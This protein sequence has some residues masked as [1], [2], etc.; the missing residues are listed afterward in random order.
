MHN[1]YKMYVEMCYEE[2]ASI[3]T[4]CLHTNY[5]IR[6]SNGALATYIHY[7]QW[8]VGISHCSV[9]FYLRKQCASTI[10]VYFSVVCG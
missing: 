10:V 6:G 5:Q 9:L 3:F 1:I 2:L 4:V 7:S 8:K